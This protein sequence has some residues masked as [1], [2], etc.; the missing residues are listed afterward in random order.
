M[1]RPNKC[2]ILWRNRRRS[3]LFFIDLQDDIAEKQI[4]TYAT[5]QDIK[6]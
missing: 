6:V 1:I 2:N 5:R 4:K 3:D